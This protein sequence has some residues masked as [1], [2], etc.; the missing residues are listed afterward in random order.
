MDWAGPIMT[1]VPQVVTV[2]SETDTEA[3]S[4]GRD[5]GRAGLTGDTGSSR[6]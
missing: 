5:G 3:S 6:R 4:G 1:T 2:A